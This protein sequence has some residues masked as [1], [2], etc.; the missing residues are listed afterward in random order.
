MTTIRHRRCLPVKMSIIIGSP[1][2]SN[3]V[4]WDGIRLPYTYSVENRV[5]DSTRPLLQLNVILLAT[6]SEETIKEVCEKCK[7]REGKKKGADECMMGLV[8]FHSKSDILD[9]DEGKA[10]IVFKFTCDSKHHGK[11]SDAFR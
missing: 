5:G 8:D 7:S 1:S 9:L 4:P 11:G 2:T 6:E 10:N 3:S